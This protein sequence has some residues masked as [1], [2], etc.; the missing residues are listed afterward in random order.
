MKTGATGPFSSLAAKLSRVLERIEEER[1][2]RDIRRLKA[3]LS[4]HPAEPGD[5]DARPRPGR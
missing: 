5:R 3:H 1:R 4:W 2:L